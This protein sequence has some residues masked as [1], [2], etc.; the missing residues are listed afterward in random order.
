[1]D[2]DRFDTRQIADYIK[3]ALRD[4]ED[5]EPKNDYLIGKSPTTLKPAGLNA[6]DEDKQTKTFAPQKPP[7]CKTLCLL[8]GAQ[9]LYRE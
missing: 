5:D 8:M 6:L 3:E 2:G 9:S 7:K 1:M 4:E